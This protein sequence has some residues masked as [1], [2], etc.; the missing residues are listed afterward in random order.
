MAL[1]TL[2]VG[3]MPEVRPNLIVPSGAIIEGLNSIFRVCQKRI[4][5]ITGN[6]TGD[7]LN[8]GQESTN[9]AQNPQILALEQGITGNFHFSRLSEVI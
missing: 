7:F 8:Y 1:R 5:P 3:F 4:F 9:S 2:E 6:L